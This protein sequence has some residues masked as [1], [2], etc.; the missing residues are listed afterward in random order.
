[1][2][3]DSKKKRVPA[4]EDAETVNL[5]GLEDLEQALK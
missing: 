3:S 4:V 1:M 5:T 2:K